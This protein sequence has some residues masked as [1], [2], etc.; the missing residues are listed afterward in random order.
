VTDVVLG[1]RVVCLRSLQSPA[2]DADAFTR[3]GLE[4]ADLALPSGDEQTLSHLVQALASGCTSLILDLDER[5]IAERLR[6][7]AGAELPAVYASQATLIHNTALA[8]SALRAR[9]V[10]LEAARFATG[11]VEARLVAEALEAMGARPDQFQPLEEGAPLPVVDLILASQ[12]LLGALPPEPEPEPPAEGTPATQRLNDPKAPTPP[13]R[14]ELPTR[15]P[16]RVLPSLAR[17]ATDTGR[18]LDFQGCVAVARA[19]VDLSRG[20]GTLPELDDLR[21]LPTLASVAAE[22]G[23]LAGLEE[24][25]EPE[26]APDFDPVPYREALEGVQ[27]PLRRALASAVERARKSSRRLVILDAED[28]EVLLAARLLAQQQ[29]AEPLLLGDLFK[30]E[31]R[32][33]ELGFS[34]RGLDVHNPERDKLREPYAQALHEVLGEELALDLDEARRWVS[35]PQVFAA[36]TVARGEAEGVLGLARRDR[37]L[38]PLARALAILPQRAKGSGDRKSGLHLI[39]RR[40]RTFVLSDTLGPR[41]PTSEEIADAALDAANFVEHILGETPRVAIL[42]GATYGARSDVALERLRRARDLARVRQPGLVVDGPLRAE[43]ALDGEVQTERY[44]ACALEGEP[45]NVLIVPG[46]AAARIALDLLTSVA[47]AESAGPFVWSLRHPLGFAPLRAKAETLVHTALITA[48][49][50]I[51]ADLQHKE[52]EASPLREALE[53]AV[54]AAKEAEE[55]EEAAAADGEEPDPEAEAKAEAVLPAAV[56]APPAGDVQEQP[57]AADEGAPDAPVEGGETQ[58]TGEEPRGSSA[59]EGSVEATEAPEG[60]STQGASPEP[61]EAEAKTAPE[62]APPA[63]A[64]RPEPTPEERAKQQE[65]LRRA[66]AQRAARAA[67]GQEKGPGKAPGKPQK[68]KPGPPKTKAEAEALARRRAARRAREEAAAKRPKGPSA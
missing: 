3:S 35:D 55:A 36:L 22:A 59:E 6:K 21:L 1:A 30:L 10:D 18:I 14:V 32:A 43:V 9:R 40:D 50:A 44:P 57:P 61:E 42:A 64:E 15:D 49:L 67:Q 53:R 54:Q 45:A 4:L 56:D 19:L 2:P 33:H 52:D 65:Q 60:P 25:T 58:D 37:G 17:A 62:A 39:A 12:E 34:L 41:D 28:P 8:L 13:T 11:G 66:R 26:E 47:G 20:D 46:R 7:T 29:L 24:A 68:R 38:E 48:A 51:Q 63:P 16:G 23:R 27:S 31:T 5:E